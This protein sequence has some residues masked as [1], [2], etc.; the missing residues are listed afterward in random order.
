MGAG[1][2]LAPSAQPLPTEMPTEMPSTPSP[3]PGPRVFQHLPHLWGGEIPYREEPLAEEGTWPLAV[4]LD[5]SD[6]ATRPWGHYPTYWHALREVLPPLLRQLPQDMRVAP[7]LMGKGEGRCADNWAQLTTFVPPTTDWSS[8]LPEDPPGGP[9]PLDEVLLQSAA[10]FPPVSRRSL[11]L[12]TTGAHTCGQD[13][14][15]VARI[16]E[17]AERDV[18]VH[19]LALNV[20][21]GDART[22]RCVAETTGGTFQQLREPQELPA[23]WQNALRHIR[24]GQ[25][26]VE[27]AG[28]KGRPFFPAVTVGQGEK[29]VATF[30]AWTDADLAPGDYTVSVGTPLPVVYDRVHIAL[31]H[32][33]RIHIPLGELHI[34]LAD[35]GGTPVKGEITVWDDTHGPFFTRLDRSAIIP[36]PT[37]VYSVSVRVPT[38]NEPLAFA[39]HLSLVVGEAVSRTVYLPV[40]SLSLRLRQ[41][42]EEATAF[43][44]LAPEDHPDTP[45]VAGW[46]SGHIS[47]VL[48]ARAYLLT[49]SH[50]AESPVVYRLSPVAVQPGERTTLTV[51]F[52]QGRLRVLPR[53]SDGEALQGTVTLF[54]AGMSGSPVAEGEVDGWLAVPAGTYDVRV[55]SADGTV[56]WAWD[57][58]VKSGEEK[59]VQ[60]VRPQARVWVNVVS[61][62]PAA[63]RGYVELRDAE[64]GATVGEGWAPGR[65]VVPAGTYRVVVRDFEVLGKEEI[66]GPWDWDGGREYTRTVSLP[67]ARVRVEPADADRVHIAIYPHDD[68]TRL[69]REWTD[70]LP[71]FLIAPGVY[72]IHL[73]APDRADAELW[74][75]DV[76]L[77]SG[78]YRVLKVRYGNA[79]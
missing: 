4:I 5:A 66:L 18:T 15:A 65:W 74:L 59:G 78:G 14:C 54:P 29:L 50:Y 76:D 1:V 37:G 55:R 26:R 8:L 72:D 30:D 73:V 48:P 62:V 61:D 69:L 63:V 75:D 17:R 79:E 23:A 31:G 19:V 42:D 45:N 6:P 43:V 52:A 11:L 34:A 7:F 58:T 35:A 32:R 47:F 9:L 3:T 10:A 2:S 64:S 40:G 53:A 16:L 12:L 36:L 27:V 57:V 49:L 67:L 24:G 44:T 38:W 39:R 25:L 13:P 33:T 20:T 21:D 28:V 77:P 60:V 56:L 51:N 22:L 41:G 68:R 46:G 70:P 71:D